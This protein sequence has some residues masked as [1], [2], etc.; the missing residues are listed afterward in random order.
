[1]KPKTIKLIK[2]P[3]HWLISG[4]EKKCPAVVSSIVE[5]FKD[6]NYYQNKYS[7]ATSISD[8]TSDFLWEFKKKIDKWYQELET[9]KFCANLDAYNLHISNYLCYVRDT[10]WEWNKD[11]IW[12]N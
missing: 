3:P 6:I 9:I 2:E 4:N 5:M 8:L 1:M 10:L 11:F 7:E 12:L